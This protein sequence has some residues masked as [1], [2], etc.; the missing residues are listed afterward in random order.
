VSA[1]ATAA[2]QPE[3]V[4]DDVAALAVE[5]NSAPRGQERE[6]AANLIHD[7]SATRVEDR[8]ETLIE[9]KLA[10][11]LTDQVDHGQMALPLRPP[12][13]PAELLRENRCGR[14][15]T[16]QEDAVDVGRI[17]AFTENFDGEH[18]A[19]LA[20]LQ[21]SERAR[22]LL[23]R[24]VA[25]QRDAIDSGFGELPRHVMRMRLGHTEAERAHRSWGV[26]DPPDRFH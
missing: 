1:S 25:G 11:M 16:K 20:R 24:V 7:S 14:R 18:A 26:D 2:R 4:E 15:R 9:A 21:A 23:R 5:I 22:A 10:A 17:D 12:K 3:V 19:K 8:A 6:V 13:A